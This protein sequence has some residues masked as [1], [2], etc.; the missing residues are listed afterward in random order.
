MKIHDAQFDECGTCH[1]RTRVKDEVHGCDQ[2]RKILNFDVK[3][4]VYLDV[5]V[6]RKIGNARHVFCSVRCVMS[7]LR[8]FKPPK[9]FRFMSLPLFSGRAQLRAVQQ[10]LKALR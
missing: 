4:A 5:T 2:C 8:A 10:H 1:A 9:G 3:D 6:F 7:W